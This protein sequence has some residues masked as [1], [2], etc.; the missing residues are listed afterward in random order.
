MRIA[1]VLPNWALALS[2]PRRSPRLVHDVV[3]VERGQVGQLDHG[4]RAD[5]VRPGAAAELAAS[6]VSS[7][8]NRLPPAV[9]R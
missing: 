6:T 1:T 7:G 4:R 2:V 9:I 5:D 3:V 8:R